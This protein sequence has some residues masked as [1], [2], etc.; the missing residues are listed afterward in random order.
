LSGL[1]ET[2]AAAAA[3]PDRILCMLGLERSA[4]RN[5]EGFIPSSIFARILE[6]AARATADECFGLYF[7]EHFNPKDIGPS[8]M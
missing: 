7:G 2:I 8:S 3:N 6:E 5:S 1:L 4:F